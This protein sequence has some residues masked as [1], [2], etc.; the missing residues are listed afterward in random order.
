VGRGANLILNVPPDRRGRIHTQDSAALVAFGA[1]LRNTFAHDLAQGHK[2]VWSGGNQTEQT[3]TLDL[4]KMQQF[5][6]IVLKE[7]IEKGQTI[8]SFVVEIRENGKWKEIARSTTVGNKKILQLVP[9]K[10]RKIRL[11]VK[12]QGPGSTLSFKGLELYA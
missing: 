4:G 11:R 8:Q 5:S 6:T 3:G 2:I 9:V 10:A 7:N 1:K 12:T